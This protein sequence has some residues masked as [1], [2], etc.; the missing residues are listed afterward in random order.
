[1]RIF[2]SAIGVFLV[3]SLVLDRVANRMTPSVEHTIAY[4]DGLHVP[5]GKYRLRKAMEE[6]YFKMLKMMY[7]YE[8]DHK[9]DEEEIL[10]KVAA[11]VLVEDVASR[12]GVVV[13]PEVLSQHLASQ[14]SYLANSNEYGIVNRSMFEHHIRSTYGMP[15]SEYEG[16]IEAEISRFLVHDMVKASAYLPM[17]SRVN[18]EGV[19]KTFGVLSLAYKKALNQVKKEKLSQEKAQ[20]FFEKHK[21]RYKLPDLKEVS[22][23]RLARSAYSKNVAVL[24]ENI[25]RYYQRKKDELFSIPAKFVVRKILVAAD[26]N[27]SAEDFASRAKELY[28]KSKESPQEFIKIAKKHSA[29]KDTASRGGLTKEFSRGTFDAAL[30]KEIVQL[31]DEHDITNIVKTPAGLEWASLVSRTKFSYQPL[32]DVRGKIVATLKE[33]KIDESMRSD[34]QVALKKLSFKKETFAEV[35]QRLGFSIQN[36]GKFEQGVSVKGDLAQEISQRVFDAKRSEAKHGSFRL[37]ADQIIYSVEKNQKDRYP[38]FNQVR[39]QV[40]ADCYDQQARE[41]IDQ[42]A[43]EVREQFFAGK[44]LE[45]LAKEYSHL[46]SY[47]CSA[48]VT[49]DQKDEIYQGVKAAAVFDLPEGGG[50][51]GMGDK[52][53]N[54]V[55]VTCLEKTVDKEVASKDSLRENDALG[56]END[57]VSGFVASLRRR[58]RLERNTGAGHGSADLAY[59]DE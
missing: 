20:A 41:L 51:K 12:M 5:A 13:S 43:Q 21:E 40:V 54:Y 42:V 22:Y 9:I 47:T 2:I 19:A 53:L 23:I 35:S 50:L 32:D 11:D 3:L 34:S 33:H 18:H 45:A 28:E 52:S 26:K 6:G 27:E 30:E 31:R 14:A 58:A 7:G 57:L 36:A 8:V 10:S 38:T 59:G 46:S 48:A 44:T 17:V 55:L 56:L 49:V 16:I 25:D 24:D 15:L 1:M 37:G 39:K 29:D 4:I